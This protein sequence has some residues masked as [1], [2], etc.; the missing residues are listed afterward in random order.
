MHVMYKYTDSMILHEKQLPCCVFGCF[1]FED[2]TVQFNSGFTPFF[3]SYSLMNNPPMNL[4]IVEILNNLFRTYSN[5][6]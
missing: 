3:M 1:S 4:L 2:N 5:L 6:V